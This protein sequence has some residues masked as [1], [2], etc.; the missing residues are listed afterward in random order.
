MQG[1]T[2]FLPVSSSGHLVLLQKIF[3]IAEGTLLFDTMTHVGTLTAVF[4]VLWKDIWAILKKPFQPLTGFL[5]IATVPTV[6][7]ALIFKDAI[8]KAFT[9]AGFLGWAFLLTSLALVVSDFLANRGENASGQFRQMDAVD[10]LVIGILQAIAV[11]PGVSRS[12]FTLS[13]A[14]ARRLDKDSAARFS[15]LLS[16]PV[17]LGALILQIKDLAGGN[18]VHMEIAPLIAGILTA[19]FVGFLSVRLMIR[20]VKRH[21]LW[22]FAIYT[23]LLGIA[24]LVFGI[25]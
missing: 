23:G 12:G 8:E 21:R 14:L 9:S 16:I 24:V 19:A 7:I 22:G 1:A 10:A 25:Q 20:L 17:I 18:A 3:G 6:I 13:G 15:F 5:I 11:V 2:E 4:V